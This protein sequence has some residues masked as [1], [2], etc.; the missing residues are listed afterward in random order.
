MISMNTNMA[1]M[2]A[3]YNVSNTNVNLQRSLQRLSSGL[4]I[5]SSSDDPGGLAVSMR[6]SAAIRRT[7]ATDRNVNNAQSFLSTQ[8][9]VLEVAGKVLARLAELAQ[10]NADVTKTTNDTTLYKTEF[11]ELVSSIDDMGS[12]VFNG[13]PLF[14]AGG[15]S[16][17][18]ITSQDGNQ[19]MGITQANLDDIHTSLAGVNLLTGDATT[20][21]S[22]VDTAINDLATLRAQN[23]AEQ[24]RL[25]YISDILE[26][27]QINLEAA[28]SRIMDLDV[29]K[30]S[31]NLARFDILQRAGIAVL[32]QA[33]Q[34]SETTLRLLY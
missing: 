25:S 27:N 29:A 28:N 14:F 11:D 31:S 30:E 8:D 2:A 15:S 21:I 1:S 22:T 16:L 17:S 3:S 9:G 7:E 24:S 5:N 19:T 33:N 13:I 32:A 12:E 6:L 4:R 20:T 10:L 34:T 18:V 26:I 23:G